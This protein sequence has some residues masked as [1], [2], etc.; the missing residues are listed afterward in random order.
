MVSE[1]NRKGNITNG[2]LDM[3]GLILGWRILEAFMT[4]LK[5]FHIGMFYNNP[6]PLHE[7]TDYHQ[8]VP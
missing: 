2:D 5:H 4:D 6:P 7:R 3:T 8:K 1:K